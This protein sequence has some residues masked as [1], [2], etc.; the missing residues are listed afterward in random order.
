MLRRQLI[1]GLLMTIVLT[2]LVGFVY[3]FAVAGISQ[4]TMAKRANGSLVK[5]NGRVVDS[6]LLGQSFVDRIAEE[7]T[8]RLF[9]SDEPPALHVS[10]L[11]DLSGAVGAAV[12][13]GA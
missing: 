13:A 5:E 2:V 1:T 10:E 9:L 7:M 12:L 11:G 8:P 4:L 6:S 3:P